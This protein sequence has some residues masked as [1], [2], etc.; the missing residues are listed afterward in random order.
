MSD[1]EEDHL[2]PLDL[3]GSPIDPRNLWPQPRTSADGWNA[4]LKDEL[5]AIL[6][7]LVC[8][9]RLP[10]AD[11][12]RAIAANWIEAYRRYVMGE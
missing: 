1:Y 2:V 12:Q 7:R 11:A 3:G 5:E 4:N 6:G 8:S 9:G 10:L